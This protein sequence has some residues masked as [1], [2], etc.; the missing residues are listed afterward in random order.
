MDKDWNDASVGYTWIS[1]EMNICSKCG[2]EKAK[3]FGLIQSK[4]TCA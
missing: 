1:K 2:G 4:C 3:W